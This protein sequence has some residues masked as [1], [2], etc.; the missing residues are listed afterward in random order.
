ADQDELHA[1]FA[2]CREVADKK[3]E[4]F[5]EDLQALGADSITDVPERM[6]LSYLDVTSRT[7]ETPVAKISAEVDGVERRAS[8]AGAAAVGAAFRALEGIAHSGANL[9]LDSVNAITEGTDSQGE[10]TVRLE[11]DGRI[12]NGNGADTDIVIASAK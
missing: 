7:G 5:D 8:A 11:K 9:Q 12:V 3:H 10:V 2:R 1:A 4:I 6:R